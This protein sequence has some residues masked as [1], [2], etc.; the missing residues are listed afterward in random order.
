MRIGEENEASSIV[1]PKKFSKILTG[2]V[3]LPARRDIPF[4][5]VPFL[6]SKVE[7]IPLLGSMF[8]SITIPLAF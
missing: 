3:A 4:F 2:A 5:N 1:L 6:I 7:E 8:D